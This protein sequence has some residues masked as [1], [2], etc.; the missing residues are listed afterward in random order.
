VG[1]C[2]WSEIQ[3]VIPSDEAGPVRA[4][5][6]EHVAEAIDELVVDHETRRELGE[7][8]QAFAISRCD[9]SAV[10]RRFLQVIDGSFPPGW[11]CAPADTRH[12]CGAGLP[13]D[14][15]RQVVREVVAEFGREALQLTDKPELEAALISWA[16]PA[17]EPSPRSAGDADSRGGRSLTAEP[18]G[19]HHGSGQ[20]VGG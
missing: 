17:T 4:C 6:E 2:A 15:V 16:F 13:S 10:A 9:P 18:E 14:R 19:K 5:D 12:L 1:S 20:Q 8:A 11:L 7:R 3:R